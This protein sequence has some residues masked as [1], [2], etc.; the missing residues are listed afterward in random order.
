MA[1]FAIYIKSVYFSFDVSIKYMLRKNPI[2]I[3]TNVKNPWKIFDDS[4]FQEIWI[5]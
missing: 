2:K 1:S 4:N 5:C 3:S